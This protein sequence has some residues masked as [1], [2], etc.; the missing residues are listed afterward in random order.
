MP[1]VEEVDGH[2]KVD[3]GKLAQGTRVSLNQL[4]AP[5]LDCALVATPRLRDH[6]RRRIDPPHPSIGKHKQQLLETNAGPAAEVNDPG[7]I[8]SDHSRDGVDHPAVERR[9][10]PNH[11]PTDQPPHQSLR[12]TELP[13]YES[14]RLTSSPGGLAL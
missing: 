12:V 9:I 2:D 14:Q 10:T 7:Q 8:R 3:R 11:R 6:H 1:E 13:T 4:Q 5:A